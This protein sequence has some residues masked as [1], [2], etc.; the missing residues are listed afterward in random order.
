MRERYAQTVL[1]FQITYVYS[2][3]FLLMRIA[4]G[5][6][7]DGSGIMFVCLFVCF[8]FRLLMFCEKRDLE[9]CRSILHAA[10]LQLKCDGIG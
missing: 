6:I 5:I 8:L 2:N 1:T 9:L 3:L 7:R 4:N 10:R